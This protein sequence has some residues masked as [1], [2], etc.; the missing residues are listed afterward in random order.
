MEGSHYT[1]AATTRP[2]QPRVAGRDGRCGM[3]GHMFGHRTKRTV[4]LGGRGNGSLGSL[5]NTGAHRSTA[6]R[7]NSLDEAKV[8][9][10][11][12]ER[13]LPVERVDKGAEGPLRSGQR[14]Q[15]RSQCGRP[16]PDLTDHQYVR[17]AAWMRAPKCK[18][19]GMGWGRVSDGALAHAHAHAR[20]Y[21][22]SMGHGHR[23][24]DLG[25]AGFTTPTPARPRRGPGNWRRR[26]LM[27]LTG[28]AP[29]RTATPVRAA[30]SS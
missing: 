27:Q 26:R 2:P 23:T 18:E 30:W 28:T 10:S 21:P 17:E 7:C 13:L 11:E 19:Q 24:S 12:V 6:G 5:G 14:L 4:T 20:L 25:W 1:K 29:L 3:L 16:A 22:D 9:A 8:V 15:V